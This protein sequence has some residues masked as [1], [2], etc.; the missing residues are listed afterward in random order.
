MDRLNTKSAEWYLAHFKRLC[1]ESERIE[2]IYSPLN[3]HIARLHARCIKLA[4]KIDTRPA[5]MFLRKY[6][7]GADR[8][9]V[10]GKIAYAGVY[11]DERA[12]AIDYLE[13]LTNFIRHIDQQRANK[14]DC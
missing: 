7:E 8:C 3:R 4:Q 5:R 11:G 6:H 13:D 14:S 2:T 10:V 12:Q 9:E 1:Q